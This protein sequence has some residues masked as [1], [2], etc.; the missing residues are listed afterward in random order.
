MHSGA[1]IRVINLVRQNESGSRTAYSAARFTVRGGP[2]ES[3]TREAFARILVSRVRCWEDELRRRC[4]AGQIDQ[5]ILFEFAIEL[6]QG[7]GLTLLLPT[8]V[9]VPRRKSEIRG[10]RPQ[11]AKKERDEEVAQEQDE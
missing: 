8:D 3:G 2:Q 7:H 1:A 9:T 6:V 5:R 4:S 10:I 11:E